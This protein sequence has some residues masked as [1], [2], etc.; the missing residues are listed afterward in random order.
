[1][2]FSG[3][4]FSEFKNSLA[5]ILV[6]KIIPISVEIKKLL[7]EK[8]YLEQILLEGHKKANDIAS[9]KLKKIHELVGF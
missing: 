5:E 8:K 3:K 2:E 9:N 1:L 7:K 4:N 6:D